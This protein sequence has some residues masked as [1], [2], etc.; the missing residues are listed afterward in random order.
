VGGSD[1]GAERSF[2][3]IGFRKAS[4]FGSVDAPVDLFGLRWT[5]DT[6][7]RTVQSENRMDEALLM[8]FSHFGDRIGREL[9]SIP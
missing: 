5:I 6:A 1:S 7:L 8:W 9:W 2:V 4:R 3:G